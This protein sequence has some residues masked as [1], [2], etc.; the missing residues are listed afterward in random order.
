MK[1]LPY[2]QL[3]VQSSSIQ[4][5][6]GGTCLHILEPWD[7]ICAGEIIYQKQGPIHLLVMNNN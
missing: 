1:V 3:Q 7:V 2:R 4:K 6:Q 5:I